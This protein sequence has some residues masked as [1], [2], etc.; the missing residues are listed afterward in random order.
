MGTPDA[1]TGNDREMG[2]LFEDFVRG[3]LLIEC[4]SLKVYKG[5]KQ[6]EWN[7]FSER[8]AKRFP[9]METDIYVSG[10]GGPSAIIETKC[11]AEPFASGTQADSL[12]S[13]HLYQLFAYLT[14]YARS[15]PA[16]PPALG[17]LLYATAGGLF[18]YRYYLH[19]HPL[20]V[21]SVDLSQPW[22]GLRADLI[23][24]A[25][26]LETRTGTDAVSVA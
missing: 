16:E 24:L 22:R 19:G 15:C 21:R 3:F 6:I 26:E 10:A 12:R 1:Y 23:R 8:D 17:V 7:D 25:D 4:P 14:N 2:L 13:N 9:V 18:D 11:V 20:W 5:H